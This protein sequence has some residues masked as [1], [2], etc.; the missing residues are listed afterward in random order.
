[1]CASAWAAVREVRG[2]VNER[3]QL[4][5]ALM[6]APLASIPFVNWVKP[7]E[8]LHLAD[9]L[10]RPKI[11][12][13]TGQTFN[14]GWGSRLPIGSERT[15]FTHCTFKGPI[16]FSFEED[17]NSSIMFSV[18]KFEPELTDWRTLPILKITRPTDFRECSFNEVYIRG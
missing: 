8:Y 13:V 18:L 6:L 4:L 3:R 14:L 7:E 2:M 1:M 5:N 16:V 12:H 10:L 17:S 11:L 9:G 15:E